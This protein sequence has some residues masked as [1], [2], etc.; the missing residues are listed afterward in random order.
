MYNVY[1]KREKQREINSLLLTPKNSCLTKEFKNLE[2]FFFACQ[3]LWM[4]NRNV[5]LHFSNLYVKK[6]RAMVILSD[7]CF[8]YLVRMEC[9]GYF[10]LFMAFVNILSI[11]QNYFFFS[12]F[13]QMCATHSDKPCTKRIMIRA[14]NFYQ[15][16]I[17]EHVSGKEI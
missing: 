3:I 14:F 6:I 12:S 5:V 11:C 7:V 17:S 1:K 2:E 15:R 8:K 16:N 4:L 10:D 9:Q 13:F